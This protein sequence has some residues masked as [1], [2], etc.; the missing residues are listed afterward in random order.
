MIISE[1]IEVKSSLYYKEL[2]YNIDSRYIL[3]DIK[4]VP[5]GSRSIVLTKCDYCSKEKEI[6]YKDYN[7]NIK[8]GGK[9][10]KGIRTWDKASIDRIDNNK[11]YT[12]DNVQFL[13]LTMNY[14]KN[15]DDM[16]G[17]GEYMKQIAPFNLRTPNV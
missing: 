7:N 16:E 6:K 4:H 15:R 9:W 3:V 8:K 11:L 2:G 1:K 13:S 12:E 10:A 5:L 14:A 17:F